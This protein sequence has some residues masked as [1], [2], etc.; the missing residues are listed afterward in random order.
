M[1]TSLGL[2][3]VDEAAYRALLRTP[4]LGADALAVRLEL[5][6][7]EVAALLARL[8]QHGLLRRSRGEW[9]PVRPDKAMGPALLE[10]QQ[11]LDRQRAQLDETRQAVTGL[12]E[13][14]LSGRR[15]GGD[16]E[17]E[18][19]EGLPAIR[20][21]ID[22]LVLATRR[23][24]VTV[25][26]LLDLDE[27][28][29]AVQRAQDQVLIERGV[30][31][32]TVCR[33]EVREGPLLWAYVE[34]CV[35]AGEQVRLV[36]ALPPRMVISDGEVAVIPVD[37]DDPDRGVHVVWSAALLASL[38]ALFE[39]LWATGSPVS[40]PS[41]VPHRHDPRLLA[42]LAA[43][44]KDERVARNLGKGV[45]TVRREIA[46]LLLDLGATTRFE[47]GVAAARRGWL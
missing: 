10:Q 45:R 9:R 34:E 1:L 2:T 21:R 20:A 8:A 3:P 15:P 13:D 43:G 32:R 44:A 36:D 18:V 4:A 40:G 6:P 47:A 19:V 5:P 29:V 11:S 38:V 31:M 16:L 37:T 35:A 33:P 24:L 26:T 12:L 22:Q 39:A 28:G 14:Y 23:E 7:A 27:A 41:P 46:D 17:I 42:L 30:R 25:S